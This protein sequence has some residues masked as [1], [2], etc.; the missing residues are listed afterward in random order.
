MNTKEQTSETPN[1]QRFKV[2]S[3]G[4]TCTRIPESELTAEGKEL[5]RHYSTLNP[6]IDFIVL[7]APE[8]ATVA[9][10][11]IYEG[12]KEFWENHDQCYGDCVERAL[13]KYSINFEIAY[14]EAEESDEAESRWKRYIAPFYKQAVG[15][16][17]I[18]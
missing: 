8:D 2:W 4:E 17:T 3:I 11:C 14:H 6:W 16:T 18:L 10:D 13:R 7:V 5:L 12:M 9:V 1:E 15:V